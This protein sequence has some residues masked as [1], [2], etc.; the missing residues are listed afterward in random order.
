MLELEAALIKTY[1]VTGGSKGIGLAITNKLLSAG[2]RVICLSRSNGNLPTDKNLLFIPCDLSDPASRLHSFKKAL[3]N[4][5][6]LFGVVN[7]SSGPK[8]ASFNDSST[9]EYLE[10]LD[11]HLFAYDELIRLSLPKLKANGTGRILNIVSVTA[12]VPLEGLMSSN[13]LRGAILNW[14]KTLSLELAPFNITVNNVLPGYTM[15]DRL[16]EVLNKQASLKSES[17]EAIQESLLKEIP[18][19]RFA[20]PDEVANVAVFLLSDLSSYVTGTSIPVDG[21]WIKSV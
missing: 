13:L 14:A 21:G 2:Y 1:I 3:E 9:K 19:R 16:K 5:K 7:N 11:G 12:R 17:L 18:L 8:P 10:A 6:S 15:T 4:T 20:T